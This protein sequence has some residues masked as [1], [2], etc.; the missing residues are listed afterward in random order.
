MSGRSWLWR[1]VPVLVAINVGVFFLQVVLAQAQQ[2]RLFPISEILWG[3]M[4]Q[5]QLFNVYALSQEGLAE[6][7]WWQFFSH[8]FLH[9]NLLHLALNMIGLWVPGRIVERVMGSGRFVALY[10]ISAMAGGVAQ[11]VFSGSNSML[12]GASGAVCGVILAFTTIFPEAER[13]FLI[14]FILPLRLRAKYLGWG[15]T[16]S[17]FLFLVLNFE[18][19]I[20]HAAHFGGCVAGYL[21]ARLSGYGTPSFL[22][23][24][25]LPRAEI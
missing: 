13:T 19:W 22:E 25:F 11:M 5:R 17:S 7:R 1:A 12:V 14:F 20:G 24:R 10:F 18:P 15:I 21:F 23:R 8:A 3:Q 4:P 16:M 9:G 2:G 6:G